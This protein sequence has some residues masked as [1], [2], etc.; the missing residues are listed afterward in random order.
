MLSRRLFLAYA[1]ALL[2]G[3]ASAPSGQAPR[4][5]DIAPEGRMV[6]GGRVTGLGLSSVRAPATS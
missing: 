4:T 6:L 2:A 3:C 5:L 1:A